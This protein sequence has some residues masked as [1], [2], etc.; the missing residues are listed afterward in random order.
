M[1]LLTHDAAPAADALEQLLLAVET[2]PSVGVAGCKQVAWDDDQRLLDVGFTASPLGLRV[3]G[4]DRGEVDQGQ[5]DGRS[6]VLAVSGAGMLV[7]RDVWDA[8][9][10]LDPGLDRD[11]EMTAAD[12]DLCRRAHL[13]GYRVVVVPAAV[14]ARATRRPP[15][16]AARRAVLHLRL[17]AVPSLLLPFALAAVLL[18]A[19]LRALLLLTAGRTGAAADELAA[20]AASSPTRSLSP[21]PGAGAAAAAGYRPACC[22]PCVPPSRR[23]CGCATTPCTPG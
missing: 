23:C 5:H 22:A 4:V 1:W 12:L 21:A 18:L 15:R 6:D 14:M 9:G 20:A 16:R 19:P 17:A 2:A 10:G 8:L 3:T 11:V 7:R 13:A